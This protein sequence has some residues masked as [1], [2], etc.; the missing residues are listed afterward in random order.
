MVEIGPVGV[1][2]AALYGWEIMRPAHRQVCLGAPEEPIPSNGWDEM[3]DAK[4][5]SLA[6]R[7]AGDLSSV[8]PVSPPARRRIGDT[9]PCLASCLQ[10]PSYL[11]D[12]LP[13][14]LPDLLPPTSYLHA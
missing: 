10:H 6:G 12:L 3:G 2:A 9:K 1:R 14:C 13:G 11:P 8:M 4:T 7:E 5:V